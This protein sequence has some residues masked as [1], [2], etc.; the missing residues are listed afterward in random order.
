MT[1]G[2]RCDVFPDGWKAFGIKLQLKNP[3]AAAVQSDCDVDALVTAAPVD[4][5]RLL[6]EPVT[7]QSF[8]DPVEL[9]LI[10]ICPINAHTAMDATPHLLLV[11]LPGI[12]P[13][14]KNL[15]DL[16]K[17]PIWVRQTTWNDAKRPADTPKVLMTS[18][19]LRLWCRSR[20]RD[21]TLVFVGGD[22]LPRC[23]CLYGLQGI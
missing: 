5:A 20:N 3:D 7:H 21:G 13:G 17:H 12:E 8:N 4:R 18:T 10:Q 14:S 23:G 9:G 19:A 22:L 1:C 11:E 2:S 16:R 6:P 15:T